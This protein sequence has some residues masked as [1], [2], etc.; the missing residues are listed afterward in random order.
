MLR[1]PRIRDLS[2]GDAIDGRCDCR[3]ARR[4]AS[5]VKS[6]MLDTR[7]APER[8]DQVCDGDRQLRDH[9]A[10]SGRTERGGV[11]DPPDNHA[12]GD[13]RIQPLEVGTVAL[14]DRVCGGQ[15]VFMD[16]RTVTNANVYS[17]IGFQVP[18]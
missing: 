15:R 7:A 2:G 5:C 9:R 16:R 3:G 10:P 6:E 12:M 17:F 13:R 4:E 18:A 11:L 14:A 8:R 1:P